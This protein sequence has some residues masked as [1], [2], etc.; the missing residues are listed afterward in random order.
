MNRGLPQA[1]NNYRNDKQRGFR[2]TRFSFLLYFVTITLLGLCLPVARIQTIPYFEFDERSDPSK[3][4]ASRDNSGAFG[5]VIPNDWRRWLAKYSNDT[6]TEITVSHVEPTSLHTDWGCGISMRLLFYRRRTESEIIPST[7][8]AFFKASY[9][10][11]SHYDAE[12]HLREIKAYYLDRILQTHVVMPCVG[13]YLDLQHVL[14]NDE[15]RAVVREN[16]ECVKEKSSQTKSA[17]ETVEGSMMLWM[18]NL[19]QVEKEEIVESARLSPANKHDI[20]KSS[21]SREEQESALNYAI[22]HY[23]GACMKSEHNH[24]SY[25]KKSGSNSA[26]DGVFHRNYVAID[27]DRCMTPKAVFSNREI[28][29]DLHFNR[30]KLWENLVYERICKVSHKKLPVLRI[31]KD[32]ASRKDN[33]TK[34]GRI[35]SLLLKAL[36]ED[37]LSNELIKSQ[38]EAFLE[39]DERVNKLEEYIRKNCPQEV[40]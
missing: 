24:F 37:L 40:T 22:F 30:I 2:F 10:D 14:D 16:V 39:I 7:T 8:K 19:H 1:P 35:S 31:V 29:P 25:R 20:E 21:A 12:S 33:A 34:N 36:E 23:L 38:P 15:D 32:A 26:T 3:L 9:A 6:S 17:K 5:D 13:Y 27:N 18:H 4:P 11:M 28:V